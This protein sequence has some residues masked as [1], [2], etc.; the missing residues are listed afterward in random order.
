MV[1]KFVLLIDLKYEKDK[2]IIVPIAYF[3]M[4]KPLFE[5]LDVLAFKAIK[6]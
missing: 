4:Y 2:I 5:N 3:E 6:S 1:P